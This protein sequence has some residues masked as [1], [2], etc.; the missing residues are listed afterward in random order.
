[1][2]YNIVQHI[3]PHIKMNRFVLLFT[4]LKNSPVALSKTRQ[5]LHP[6]FPDE[7]AI[8][9][10]GWVLTRVTTSSD[11]QFVISVAGNS[12]ISFCVI[13]MFI[14]FWFVSSVC[15]L[16]SYIY[17]EFLPCF[18]LECIESPHFSFKVRHFSTI[19]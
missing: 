7:Y 16:P 13:L 4:T 2:L 9:C 3:A 18:D 8:S 10:S 11:I 6:Y 5:P 14:P 17:R 1:M 15:K 12:L 19:F